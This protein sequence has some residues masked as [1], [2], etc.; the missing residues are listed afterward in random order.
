MGA[1]VPEDVRLAG[2]DGLDDS[3]YAAPTPITLVL[4]LSLLSVMASRAWTMLRERIEG[5]GGVPRTETFAARLEIRA[6]T[7]SLPRD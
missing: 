7:Q 5:E 6:S 3:T 1:G 4:V 2:C